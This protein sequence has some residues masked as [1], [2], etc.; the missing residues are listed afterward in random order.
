ME[1]AQTRDI[2][3]DVV[4]VPKVE[5]LTEAMPIQI[6]V[7]KVWA[8]TPTSARP[9]SVR[10]ILIKNGQATG[11]YVTLNAG[12][13]WKAIFP[14]LD[15]DAVWTVDEVPVPENFKKTITS[16]GN[17]FTITNEYIPP[18]SLGTTNL[19]T[20]TGDAVRIAALIAA[21]VIASAVIVI[22]VASRRKRKDEDEVERAVQRSWSSVYR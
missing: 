19:D 17:S 21:V 1:N 11:D 18:N 10:V 15:P 13:S 14:G 2:T 6:S 4:M 5:E 8:N 3:Y 7:Q 22:L 16:V 20:Q 9:E 12:N